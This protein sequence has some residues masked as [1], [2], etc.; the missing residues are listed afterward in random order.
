MDGKR[1]TI[2]SLHGMV[3]AA[4]PL[5]ALAGARLLREGGNAFDAAVATVAALNVVEP[6]M[7]GLAGMGMATCYVAAEQRVRTLDFVT[8]VPTGF[9]AAQRTRA[10][11]A[12]GPHSIGTPGNLAGWCALAKRYGNK[13]RA[14]LFAP[15]I[16][17]AR[18]GFPITEGNASMAG[19]N[20]A[21]LQVFDE[22]LRTYTDAG[23]A[24]AA[25]WILRQPAL[26]G[27]YEAIVADGAAHLYDGPLGRA[28]ADHIQSLGGCLSRDDLAAVEPQWL[29]PLAV[30]YRDVTIHSLPPPAEAFQCLL[31]MRIL[32]GFDIAGLPQNGAAHFDHVWRAIRLA[33]DVRIRNNNASRDIIDQLLS[34]DHVETLRAQVGADAPVTG[35]TEQW[36]DPEAAASTVDREHTTS[37]SVADAEG[38]IVCITQSLGAMFGSGVVIPGTGVCMNNF[39]FWGELNAEGAN[40]MAP[41]APLALPLAPTISTRDGE[42]VLALG[43]PGSYGI[44]QTQAQALVQHIDYGLPVQDAIEAPRGRLLDGQYVLAE[45]RID[46]AA[47]DA[48]RDRGHEVE[49]GPAFTKIVGGMQG[50]AR[51]PA[52]GALT[53]GADPRRD[54]YAVSP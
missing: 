10:Q 19:E 50:V 18:D 31:T 36:P 33:A 41:G 49:V 27:T 21:E 32:D 42:P 53:G 3:A 22:W 13:D 43:T 38:N 35:L 34:D 46:A 5:A 11:M 26:A 7:S 17:L 9:D 40:Y 45:S 47:I 8:R 12:R 30:S 28:M 15:A 24:L 44:C 25:G 54:G 1:P 2:A 23:A 16:E 6:Y 37:L 39:L 20:L 52:T 14:R 29:D 4:H 51:D 48:L